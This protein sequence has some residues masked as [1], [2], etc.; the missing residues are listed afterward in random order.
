MSFLYQPYP[1]V[2]SYARGIDLYTANGDRYIDTFAG[3]GVQAFGHSYPPLLEKLQDK[4]NRMIHLSNF[5][6][7]PDLGFVTERLLALSGQKGEVV[8]TNSG[9]EATEVALKA[10]CKARSN[11]KTKIVYFSHSFHGRTLGALSVNGFERFRKPFEPLMVDTIQLPWN[12]QQA[13]RDF[14][15]EE[16]ENLLAVMLEPIQGSAGII[17]IQDDFAKVIMN[18]KWVSP[19]YLVCDEVQS[20]LGR[21]GKFFAYEHFGLKPDIVLLGKALGGGL[22]LGAVLLLGETVNLL[23]RGD[24]GSTFAPNP[25]ALAGA[26]FLLENLPGMLPIIKESSNYMMQ[27]LQNQLI[28]FYKEIRGKGFMIG[29]ELNK[30]YPDVIQRAMINHKLLIN[31]INNRIIRLLPP[32][33]ISRPEIDGIVEKMTDLVKSL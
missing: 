25:V 3:I 20:G 11:S 30:E 19:F 7:D 21:T 17:P 2:I 27:S 31:L 18:A 12:D 14:L 23:Q 15:K 1:L 5:F 24:H 16:S 26:R 6:L 13:F 28:G 32:L 22:P 4:M 29:L 10:L 9:T 8:F 33:N